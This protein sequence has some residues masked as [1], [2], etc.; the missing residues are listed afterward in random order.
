MLGRRRRPHHLRRLPRS[1]PTSLPRLRLLRRKLPRMPRVKRDRKKIRKSSRRRLPR[2]RKK[3]RHL[4]HAQ[5]RAAQ[6]SFRL[7]RSLDSH[8]QT[9]FHLSR[10]TTCPAISISA[11]IF[12]ATW[13][14]QPLSQVCRHSSTRLFPSPQQKIPAPVSPSPKFSPPLPA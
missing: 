12:S 9:R 13:R 11:V 5:S 8:L 3:L 14:V 10:I 2:S 6:S 7:H 4:P 1:T